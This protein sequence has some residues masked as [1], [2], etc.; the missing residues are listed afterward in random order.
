MRRARLC[1]ANCGLTFLLAPGLARAA[2][3][4]LRLDEAVRLALARNENA[5]I[6]EEQVAVAG[7]AVEKARTA[8]FPLVT[9]T[10]TDTLQHGG[11][12]STPVNA[13]IGNAS[14]NQPILNA[15]AWPLLRQAERLLDAQRAT[16]TDQKRLLAFSA[17]Q[18]FFQTLSS[19]QV[20]EAA[21][22]S[23]AAATANLN[24]TTAR[25]DAGL[26]SS[27]DVTRAQLDLSLSQQQV[28]T[29][30]GTVQ[31]AYLQLAFVLNSPIQGPLTAPESTLKAASTPVTRPDD[32]VAIGLQK[33]P[34]LMASRH[35][36]RAA[37]LF[38]DEP[39]LRL[40]P[41]VSVT[42]TAAGNSASLTGHTFNE[43]LGATATWTVFDAGVRYADKHSRDASANISD[44]QYSLLARSV[45]NDVR[46]AVATLQAAQNALRLAGDAVTASR[47]SV[48][49]TATLYKQGLATAL[50]LTNANDSRFSAEVTYS[51]AELATALAYLALRQ[52]MGLDPLGT[53][54]R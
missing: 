33:R 39:L 27:N 30:E 37:H 7:A 32:L 21:K 17:A 51:S 11:A 23:V 5:H 40:I 48:D 2:D 41:T 26:N 14:I 20:V 16:A 38:A 36:A 28:A 29:N 22:R 8:F 19:E 6:A 45:A 34:D 46:D 3:H 35:S 1:V 12:G 9:T 13:E 47:K 25:A 49:E 43:T 31:R 18:A 54:L 44:L 10:G 15:S 50:E 4:P 52:A 24:D 53:E 42:G